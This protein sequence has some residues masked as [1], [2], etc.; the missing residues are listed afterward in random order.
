LA[1][2]GIAV[3]ALA[4]ALFEV[5]DLRVAKKPW[6]IDCKN[7]NDLTLDRFPLP[8]DDPLWHPSLNEAHFIKHAQVKLDH[9]THHAGAESKLMYINLISGQERPLGYYNRAFQAVSDFEA[10]EIIVVQGA[11]DRQAPN[12][13]Q[14]AF[15]TFLADL[16]KAL[17]QEEE[18]KQ[19]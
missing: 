9:V 16:K 8:A 12:C 14:A 10:A 19:A 1:K 2:E 5:A 15:T 11:L 7:Y 13:Y 3:E 6:F 18:N 17:H 4:D